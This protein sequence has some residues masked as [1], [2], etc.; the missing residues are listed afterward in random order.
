MAWWTALGICAVNV[1]FYIYLYGRVTRDPKPGLQWVLDGLGLLLTLCSPFV[2]EA[3]FPSPPWMPKDSI[4]FILVA[5]V[6]LAFLVGWRRQRAEAAQAAPGRA[7]DPLQGAPEP[8]DLDLGP[9][10]LVAL[11]AVVTLL[12]APLVALIL[13]LFVPATVAAGAS[14]LWLFAVPGLF[15]WRALQRRRT[16]PK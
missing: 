4:K 6:L 14:L 15:I 1:T 8:P 5:P 11:V 13:N 3:L 12:G 10:W 7:A 2:F 16:L 9:G